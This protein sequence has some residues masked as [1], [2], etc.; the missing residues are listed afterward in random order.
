M[1]QFRFN[2]KSYIKANMKKM[3]QNE[4]P[5]KHLGE[6]E[7]SSIYFRKRPAAAFCGQ[8]GKIIIHMKDHSG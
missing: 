8:L 3:N 5:I 6:A 4:R 2:K 1:A 7:I